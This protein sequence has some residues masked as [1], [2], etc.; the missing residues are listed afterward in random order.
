MN[1]LSGIDFDSVMLVGFLQMFLGP[2]LSPAA[3]STGADIF[4]TS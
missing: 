2:I 4:Y 3:V 1:G